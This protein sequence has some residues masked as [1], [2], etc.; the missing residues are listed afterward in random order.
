ML[1]VLQLII[2]QTLPSSGTYAK[3]YYSGPFLI[4]SNIRK[5]C[6]AHPTAQI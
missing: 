1:G 6:T 3:D 4:L 5:D 2:S